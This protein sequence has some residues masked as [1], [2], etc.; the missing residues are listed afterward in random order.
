MNQEKADIGADFETFCKGNVGSYLI[1]KA[2]EDEIN[3]LRKIAK[4][5]PEDKEEIYKLQMEAAVPKRVINWIA[6]I[7]SEGKAAKFEMEQDKEVY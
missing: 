3:A 4:V 6:Q 2:E 7:I 1:K 5:N